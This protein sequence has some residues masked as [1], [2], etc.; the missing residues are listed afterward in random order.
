MRGVLDYGFYLGGGDARF[1]R[2]LAI[3]RVLDY[4]LDLGGGQA[5]VGVRVFGVGTGRGESG[6]YKK[7][8]GHDSRAADSI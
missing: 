7:Q 5:G 4:G 2:W 3:Q 6:D 1:E 8:R